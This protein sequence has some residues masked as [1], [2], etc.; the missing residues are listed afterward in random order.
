MDEIENYSE[1]IH[2]QSN[3]HA[4]HIL[5]EGKERWVL[6]VALSTAL[7]AVLAAITG[8]LA[9]EHADEAMLAQIHASDQWAYYQAKGIKSETLNQT[10]KLLLAFGKTPIAADADKIKD[11]KKEQ[12]EIKKQAEEFQKESDV[13]VAKHSVFARGITLFQISIAIGAISIIVKR[14]GLWLVSIGF[15]CIGIFFLIQG[16]WF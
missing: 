11:N 12:A 3:E 4:H 10:N 14:K 7:I 13:H 2:E 1:K 16:I 15:A 9:G 6:F 8:L 5:S